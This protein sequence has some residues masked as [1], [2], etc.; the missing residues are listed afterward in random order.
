MQIIA[1]RVKYNHCPETQNTP[2]KPTCHF[3]NGV[4]K[5]TAGW[6]DY[7]ASGKKNHSK[8]FSTVLNRCVAV[9]KPPA[10][11]ISLPTGEGRGGAYLSALIGLF[12]KSL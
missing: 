5:K 2:L 1:F 4:G 9:S 8:P 3:Q 7:V 10:G 12:K 11:S 6:G